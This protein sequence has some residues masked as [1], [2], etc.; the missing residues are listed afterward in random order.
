MRIA[1]DLLIA[2]KKP[3]GM[4]FATRA[5]LEGL[6]RIDQKDEYIIITSNPKEYQELATAPNIRVHP[7]KLRSWRAVLIQ[8][9]L[10]MPRIL[11][12]LQPDVLHVP[13]F[14]SPIGWK[15]PLVIT[16]HDLA[17]LK[18]PHQLPLRNRIYWQYMLRESVRHAQRIIVVSEQTRSELISYWK[19]E[20]ER[21]CLIHNALR[22][23]LRQDSI[24]AG[25]IQAMQR[26]YG[27]RYLLHVGRI[28]PRK[29]VEKLVQAFDLLAARF[30]DVHLVLAGGAGNGSASVLEQIEASPYRERIHQTGW[31]SEQD[32]GPLYASASALVF[33]STHEGFGI[34]TV[35]AMA[36]GTPVVASPEAASIEVAGEAVLRTDC[37]DPSLLA[38]AITQVLT[39]EDLRERLIQMG[40]IQA[41]PFTCEAS[42][43]RTREVYHEAL[44]IEGQ[45]KV[46]YALEQQSVTSSNIAS[47]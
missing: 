31:V 29:N 7:V 32:L 14:V 5:L 42:A 39:D 28:V 36:C 8:H 11:R 12:K 26:R 10:L 3:G 40:R 17:F 38:D 19:V 1:I 47:R 27:S 30:P 45:G 24:S 2:E 43:L 22:P 13:A 21:I 23:S 6:V 33:P 44:I 9:Q 35:E 18:L 20:P 34:P 16:V 15:G 46:K 41:R 37:S 4:L 25:E